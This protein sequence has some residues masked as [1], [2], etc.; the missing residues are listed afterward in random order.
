MNDGMGEYVANQVIKGMIKRNQ[1]IKGSKIL[2]LGITFKENCPD[3][4]NS[5]VIDVIK[6]LKNYEVDVDIYDP[7]A[8]S[9]EV[10]YKYDLTILS[11]E[12]K[13]FK[14]KTYNVVILAVAHEIFQTMDIQQFLKDDGFVYDVKGILKNSSERL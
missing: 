3:I 10:K 14:N 13:T 1:H 8:S 6:T 4:R 7:H 9:E 11:D 5:K 2:I 12:F